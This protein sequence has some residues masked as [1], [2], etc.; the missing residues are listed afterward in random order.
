M[1]MNMKRI[2]K[3]LIM[4][5]FGILMFVIGFLLANKMCPAP[6]FDQ[7]PL[8]QALEETKFLDFDV[9]PVKEIFKGIPAPV[10]FASNPE[11]KE[12]ETKLNK[13]AKEGPNFA[14][15]Y[16]LVEIGCGTECKRYM[17][18]DVISGKV[19][20]LGEAHR[21]VAVRLDSKL[22]IVDPPCGPYP[23][24]LT[25]CLGADANRPAR[26]YLMEKDGLRLIYTL[27]CKYD[28]ITKKQKCESK[29]YQDS[30]V[31][32]ITPRANKIWQRG[33]V[34][35]VEWREGSAKVGLFLIDKS[36]EEKSASL[37]QIER[38][39]LDNEGFYLY[40]V[41]QNFKP[42]IYKWCIES[43]SQEWTCTDYFAIK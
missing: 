20:S 34:Y 36:L 27:N 5:G 7:T 3:I 21:G 33:K 9:Y 13:Q 1:N 16:T 10:D 24:P 35:S 2:Y 37:S 38:I 8:P 17:I 29:H 40:K 12:F 22:L 43:N 32:F 30:K 6:V 4:G 18:V 39:A 28:Q 42:G 26:F 15:H 14:G 11:A 25:S 31:I 19:F 41:P 23:P